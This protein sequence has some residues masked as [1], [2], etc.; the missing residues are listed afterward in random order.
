MLVEPGEQRVTLTVSNGSFIG[1]AVE[2]AEVRSSTTLVG[3]CNCAKGPSGGAALLLVLVVLYVRR[4]ARGRYGG[5][6]AGEHPPGG[7]AGGGMP[8]SFL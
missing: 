1:E 8:A 6:S 5:S 3:G 4:V 7:A 2:V